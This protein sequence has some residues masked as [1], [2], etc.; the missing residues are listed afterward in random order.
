MKVVEKEFAIKLRREGKSYREILSQV[1]VAKSTLSEWFKSVQLAAPQK[2]RITQL[3]IDARLR[4][5]ASKRDKRLAEVKDLITK[6][7]EE[8]GKL[9]ERELWLIG[10]A[11]YWAEGSK[12]NARSI[13]TGILFGNM[14][15]KMIL[16]FLRWLRSMGVPD[17]DVYFELYVHKNRA[18]EVKNFVEWWIEVLDLPKATIL[19]TYLKNGNPATNRRNIAD[20]YHGLFRIRVK[21]STSLNRK[22]NGWIEGIVSQ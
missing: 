9:S 3:R 20:L 11:L 19:R 2:Q 1:P 22:V 18:S 12:Q 15:F 5:A 6:G 17:D 21:S 16:V 4:G 10:T 14:D 13:S 8:V 7:K